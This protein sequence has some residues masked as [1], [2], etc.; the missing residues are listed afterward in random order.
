[1]F[2][3]CLLLRIIIDCV[4][5]SRDIQTIQDCLCIVFV[6]REVRLP[7]LFCR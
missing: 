1:M 6:D 3:F 7:V 4:V 5:T 2:T